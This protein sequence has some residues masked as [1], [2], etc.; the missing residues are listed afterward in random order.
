MLSVTATY[1]SI[2]DGTRCP[3]I[4]DWVV[5]DAI[6]EVLV[7]A[8]VWL[9]SLGFAKVIVYPIG[10]EVAGAVKYP[11]HARR[12]QPGEHHRLCIR[13]PKAFAVGGRTQT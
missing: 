3:A 6:A 9:M 11:Y 7:A 10:G 5:D 13:Q 1:A 4:L 8:D 2:L 12:G